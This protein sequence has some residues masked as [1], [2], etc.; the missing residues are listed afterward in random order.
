MPNIYEFVENLQTATIF[1][2]K[3]EPIARSLRETSFEATGVYV[4]ISSPIVN[5]Q[6]IHNLEQLDEIVPTFVLFNDFDSATEATQ[7]AI[8]EL[9]A[10]H[11]QYKSVVTAFCHT[12]L[13]G[14]EKWTPRPQICQV[15]A[16]DGYQLMTAS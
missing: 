2:G 9:M 10:R 1:F 14:T 5:D 16:E 6:V 7:A 12:K 3:S 8:L 15:T 4:E 13:D 11:N